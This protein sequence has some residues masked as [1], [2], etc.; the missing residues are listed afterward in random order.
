[1]SK[2]YL[3]RDIDEELWKQYKAACAHYGINIREEFLRHMRNIV[4]DYYAAMK[5]SK[6]IEIKDKEKRGK[7]T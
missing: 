4:S 3:L 7:K 1:M 2:S 6:P 5:K